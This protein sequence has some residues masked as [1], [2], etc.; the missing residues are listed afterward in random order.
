MS[1]QD[2]MERIVVQGFEVA[3]VAIL[4][5]STLLAFGSAGRSCWALRS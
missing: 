4:V 3:G 2:T 1:Y 5:V